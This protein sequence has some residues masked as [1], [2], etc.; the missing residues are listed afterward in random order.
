M[1]KGRRL[2]DAM[3]LVLIHHLLEWR[4]ATLHVG[5]PALYFLSCELLVLLLPSVW[6]LLGEFVESPVE[7]PE[8]RTNDSVVFIGAV[9]IA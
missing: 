2:R 5:L 9:L 3:L 1:H 8:R 7:G 6:R 4:Q